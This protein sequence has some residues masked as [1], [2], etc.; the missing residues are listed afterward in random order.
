MTEENTPNRYSHGREQCSLSIREVLR[1]IL[2]SPFQ[3]KE[4]N[5]GSEMPVAVG[6][7]LKGNIEN[8]NLLYLNHSNDSSANFRDVFIPDVSLSWLLRV[9]SFIRCPLRPSLA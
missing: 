3:Q 8:R 6:V 7:D 1:R 5:G 4:R 2:G 9:L